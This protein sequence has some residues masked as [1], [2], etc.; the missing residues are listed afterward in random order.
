MAK[1]SEIKTIVNAH[2]NKGID[3]DSTALALTQAGISFSEIQSTIQSVGLAN[4]WILTPEKIS[5]K[6]QEHVK[7]KTITHFLD[8][9]ELAS[10]LDLSS[11]SDS[12]KQK[13]II[14]FSGVTKSAVT[15]SKKFKQFR[16]SGYMGTIA[17]WILSNPDFTHAE[18]LGSGLIADAPHRLEYFEEF[19]AYQS[20]FKGLKQA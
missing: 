19:L 7:G 2:F 13:A 10:S 6:V 9:A 8:V 3:L 11:L 4:D 17:E 20:F 15:P 12:E 18:L 1:K 16:N 14:D 5:A